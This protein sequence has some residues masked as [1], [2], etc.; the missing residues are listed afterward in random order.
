M[1]MAADR[2]G[3]N[4]AA[5]PLFLAKL[6]KAARASVDRPERVVGAFF[7]FVG[8]FDVIHE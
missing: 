2:R 5:G 3:T 6:F 8:I 7:A 4:G 1:L